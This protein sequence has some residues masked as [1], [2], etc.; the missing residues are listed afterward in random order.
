MDGYPGFGVVLTRLMKYF[1]MDVASL[2]VVSG[3]SEAD[4]HRLCS[5]GVPLSSHLLG[6]SAAFGLH[7]ADIY[8]IADVSVPEELSPQ[9]VAAEPMVV[10]LVE[11]VM[12][13]LPEQRLHV[14]RL[15]EDASQEPRV[16]VAS[17]RSYD[18][19]E[20]GFG[21]LL[22]NLCGNRN[23]HSLPATAKSL[24]LLTDGQVYLASSTISAIGRGRAP[25]TSKLV[26]GFAVTLG[27]PV[28]VL[29]A[30]IGCEPAGLSVALE[31]TAT[32]LADL[33]W[34]CRRLTATQAAAIYDEAKSMQ[35][36]TP[37]DRGATC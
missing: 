14:R 24:A 22:I 7:A 20:A 26:A 23:L 31:S 27:I 25:V 2:S 17:S 21:A 28:G 8:V 10:R 5:G 6:L 34:N 15:V 33:L 16:S 1:Q 12:D 30:I 3:I 19:R 13:L 29:A 36:S 11:I 35:G 9:D 32:E 18:Q 37:G 4:F